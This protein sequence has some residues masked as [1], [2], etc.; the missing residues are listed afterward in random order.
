M[1]TEGDVVEEEQNIMMDRKSKL[2]YCSL[3]YK[4]T[5]LILS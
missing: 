1:E 4:D 2:T 5:N 3:K